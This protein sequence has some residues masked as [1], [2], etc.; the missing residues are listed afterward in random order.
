MK[1]YFLLSVLLFLTGCGYDGREECEQAVSIKNNKNKCRCLYRAAK[2]NGVENFKNFL[3]SLLPLE[4]PATIT[5]SEQAGKI[6][7]P[8]RY[9]EIQA[10]VVAACEGAK[11]FYKKEFWL[12][13]DAQNVQKAI[14]DGANVNAKDDDWNSPLLLAVKNK[15]SF[16]VI[17][18]LVENGADINAQDQDGFSALLLTV[19]DN[20]NPDLTRFLI[21]HGADMNQ[22]TIGG[23]N[24]L[25]L[26][27]GFNQNPEIIRILIQNGA[28][29]DA[30]QSEGW[31]ALMFA[32]TDNPNPEVIKVLA[33]AGADINIAE[34]IDGSTVLMLACEYNK[35]PAVVE[36]LISL[37]ADVRAKDFSGKTALD[38]AEKNQNLKSSGVYTKLLNLT[39]ADNNSF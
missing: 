32:G 31:N 26:A 33:E 20:T 13:A 2:E 10:K 38:Y 3:P 11:N 28:D 14:D 12:T 6:S 24:A 35:N 25:I 8:Q 15:L 18:I 23:A 22:V 34:D 39:T 1:F 16:D 19:R 21:E 17:K 4:K 29:I 5:S 27:S 7:R 9:S 30:R 37:G 36:T